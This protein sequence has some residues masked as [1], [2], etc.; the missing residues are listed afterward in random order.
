MAFEVIEFDI[1]EMGRDVLL[2]M[3]KIV[4]YELTTK[5]ARTLVSELLPVFENIVGTFFFKK[6]LQ[7]K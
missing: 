2:D 7:T 1:S 4:S 3:K 5:L 6:P